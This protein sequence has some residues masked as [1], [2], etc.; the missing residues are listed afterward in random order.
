MAR[1]E[2][3]SSIVVTNDGYRFEIKYDL[4]IP[5]G[6]KRKREYEDRVS[7]AVMR[8]LETVGNAIAEATA[9][10]VAKEIGDGTRD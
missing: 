4:N 1:T 2:L 9:T 10:K 3:V 7:E 6:S 5:V 8:N